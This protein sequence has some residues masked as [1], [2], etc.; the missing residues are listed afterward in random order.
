M[1]I[2]QIFTEINDCIFFIT[3]NL[4]V[5]SYLHFPT[6]SLSLAL[7]LSHCHIFAATSNSSHSF[8]IKPIIIT[9]LQAFFFSLSLSQKHVHKPLL[10]GPSRNTL[11][12]STST[13]TISSTTTTTS[14][15]TTTKH[16]HGTK[17]KPLF[18]FIFF[19]AK[20]FLE[21]PTLSSPTPPSLA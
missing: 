9:L 17:S 12:D 13:P 8:H 4:K 20:P 21:P 1:N 18:I 15:T 11:V 10:F 19:K 6:Y 5:L 16:F 7:S 14:S 3:Q 2:Y